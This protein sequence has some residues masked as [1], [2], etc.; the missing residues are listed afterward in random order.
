MIVLHYLLITGW[1]LC[2]LSDA[3]S[4]NI[5]KNVAKES[6]CLKSCFMPPDGPQL[7]DM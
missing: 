2:T 3:F 5:S 4:S 6:D 1:I 7:Q